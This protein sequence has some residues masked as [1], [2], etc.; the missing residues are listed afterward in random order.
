M[1]Y[2]SRGLGLEDN[3]FKTWKSIYPDK[4]SQ[5]RNRR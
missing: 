5:G 2:L 1:D 3:P 4:V